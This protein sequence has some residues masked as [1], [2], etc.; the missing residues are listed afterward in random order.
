[1]L[2]DVNLTARGT[3]LH[4]TVSF[5]PLCML[6]W[7]RA[8]NKRKKFKCTLDVNIYRIMRRHLAT[9]CN[10]FRYTLRSRTLNQSDELLSK[11]VE[12]FDLQMVKVKG[13]PLECGIA[14]THGQ[15]LGTVLPYDGK[16]LEVQGA[17]RVTRIYIITLTKKNVFEHSLAGFPVHILSY[18]IR[19]FSLLFWD[20]LLQQTFKPEAPLKQVP[21]A[22][23]L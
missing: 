14:L 11:S 23:T 1:M 8:Q 2:C 13:I 6:V 18:S 21:K 10:R 15:A 12:G 17:L 19:F 9:T 7:A 20:V 4:Q 5:E 16:L 3:S 22:Q